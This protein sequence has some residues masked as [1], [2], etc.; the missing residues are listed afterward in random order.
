MARHVP[1]A[2]V[3]N[4]PVY[5]A[6]AQSGLYDLLV[7]K[8]VG[9]VVVTGAETDPSGEPKNGRARSA[10]RNEGRFRGLSMNKIGSEHERW[11]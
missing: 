1:P 10:R 5:S 11:P 2:I 9:T 8:G 7:G 4:K 3:V 6:F